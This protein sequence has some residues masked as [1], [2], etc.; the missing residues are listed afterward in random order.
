VGL[1]GKLIGWTF[2]ATLLL[3]LTIIVVAVLASSGSRKPAAELA[4]PVIAAPAAG[5]PAELEPVEAGAVGT[6]EHDGQQSV[7][8]A[9]SLP[10]YHEMLAAEL[11]L[12]NTDPN[13]PA[14]GGAAI[15]RLS[16]ANRVRAYAVGSKVRVLKSEGRPL[17]VQVLAG[18]DKGERGWVQR[19]MVTVD[20][21]VSSR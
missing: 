15:Y 10:D 9:R 20:Q 12:Y 11:S 1:I 2:K 18:E 17:L 19:E 5:A 3:V 14:G 7:W 13:R 21:R 16:K 6:L 4:A 8:L